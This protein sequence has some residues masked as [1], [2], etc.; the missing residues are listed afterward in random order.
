M[1]IPPFLAGVL[2]VLLLEM[3]AVVV[4]GVAKMNKK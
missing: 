2:T 4:A 3:A 1:Y